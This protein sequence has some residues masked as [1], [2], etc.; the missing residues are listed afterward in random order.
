MRSCEEAV[1]NGEEAFVW[2]LKE[3]ARMQVIPI[4]QIVWH[5]PANS[6]TCELTVVSHRKAYI[7][8]LSASDLT[9]PYYSAVRQDAI[10]FLLTAIK[11]NRFCRKL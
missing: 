2:Q 9:D 6:D 11:Q 5:H 1:R 3:R 7:L 4:E 10:R 8:S